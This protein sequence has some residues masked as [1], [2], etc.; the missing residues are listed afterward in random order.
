MDWVGG[1]GFDKLLST[2]AVEQSSLVTKKFS[3]KNK[4]PKLNDCGV[5]NV[6]CCSSLASAGTPEHHQTKSK[7]KKKNFR[8][9]EE[10]Y[11]PF[12]HAFRVALGRDIVQ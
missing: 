4:S 6:W 8:N 12:R 11:I 9:I 5:G 2:A 10:I 1:F 3:P 7:K